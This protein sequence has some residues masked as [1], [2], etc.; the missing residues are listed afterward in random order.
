MRLDIG[1]A[2]RDQKARQRKKT[3]PPSA[4]M[5]LITYSRYLQFHIPAVTTMTTTNILQHERICKYIKGYNH[6]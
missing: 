2:K 4:W 5:K 6:M 3:P 1:K